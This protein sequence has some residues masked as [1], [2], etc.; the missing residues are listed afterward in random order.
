MLHA[1]VSQY[2]YNYQGEQ[3]DRQTATAETKPELRHHVPNAGSSAGA[4]RQLIHSGR[5]RMTEV[6]SV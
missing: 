6:I 5:T 1:Q 2:G 4:S 3:T